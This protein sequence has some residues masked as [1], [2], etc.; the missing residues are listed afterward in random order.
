[1]IYSVDRDNP[2]LSASE[3]FNLSTNAVSSGEFVPGNGRRPNGLAIAASPLTFV[4][5]GFDMPAV[6]FDGANVVTHGGGNAL[7]VATDAMNVWFTDV[8]GTTDMFIATNP[9]FGNTPSVVERF[10]PS[11]TQVRDISITADGSTL[12]ATLREGTSSKRIIRDDEAGGTTLGNAVELLNYSQVSDPTLQELSLDESR[13]LLY[14]SEGIGGLG[15]VNVRVMFTDG[16]W[17]GTDNTVST[18][19]GAGIAGEFDVLPAP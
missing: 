2:I 13:D 8:N 9:L 18:F 6:V 12:F 10:T 11:D 4:I 15:D 7:G 14:W 1:V 17:G 5:G 3:V 19:D 16:F